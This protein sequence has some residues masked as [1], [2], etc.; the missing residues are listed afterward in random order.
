MVRL[1]ETKLNFLKESGMNLQNLS[2]YR[3][4]RTFVAVILL[5]GVTASAHCVELYAVGRIESLL[6]NRASLQIIEV[7]A[8]TSESLNISEGDWVS[9]DL[10]QI[11]T[12]KSRRRSIQFGNIVEIKLVGNPATEYETPDETLSPTAIVWSAKK[13]EHVKDSKQYE[14]ESEEKQPRIWTQ[15]E[16]VRGTVLARS[17]NIYIKERGLGRRDRGLYVVSEDWKEKLL[18][19]SG[20]TVVIYGTTH[21]VT[22]ASGTFDVQNIMRIHPSK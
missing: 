10:P 22:A 1:C 21:R 2:P 5:L 15:Q 16:T 17:G 12:S 7:L 20:Q 11:E 6:R 9:F 19:F 4:A 13:V 8:S 14:P 3:M 18:P